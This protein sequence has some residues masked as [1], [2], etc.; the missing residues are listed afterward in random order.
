MATKTT[1]SKKNSAPKAEA[2]E[3]RTFDPAAMDAAAAEA[4]KVFNRLDAKVQRA[5]AGFWATNYLGAGHKRLG[6]LMVKK[7]KEFGLVADKKA[8]KAA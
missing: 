4:E 8:S 3:E 2:K 5:F 6:R 7:A 1:T